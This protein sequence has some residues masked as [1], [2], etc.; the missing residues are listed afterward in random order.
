MS[1]VVPGSSGQL[2]GLSLFSDRFST[3]G[4]NRVKGDF[5]PTPDVQM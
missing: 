3:L 5:L 4:E 1:K 2:V